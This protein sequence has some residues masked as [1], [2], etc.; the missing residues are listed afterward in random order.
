MLK[1]HYLVSILLNLN[2]GKLLQIEPV[3][4]WLKLVMT[5][6]LVG[7][8]ILGMCIYG[9]YKAQKSWCK[10]SKLLSSYLNNMFRTSAISQLGI[11]I[12]K[13]YMV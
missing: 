13:M 8:C 2:I 6:I 4:T 10:Y 5:T 7:L 12:M 3:I 11:G 9:T 1:M